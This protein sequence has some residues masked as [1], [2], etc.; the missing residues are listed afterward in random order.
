MSEDNKPVITPP[1]VPAVVDNKAH[2]AQLAKVQKELDE[3]KEAARKAAE[4]APAPRN[5][6]SRVPAL[7]SLSV[8]E[9]DPE[10]IS[11]ENSTTRE[12]FIGTREEFCEYLRS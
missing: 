4:P 3:Y 7:W 9:N 6:A 12:Q 2:E 11:G 1:V 8:D 5:P 10:L